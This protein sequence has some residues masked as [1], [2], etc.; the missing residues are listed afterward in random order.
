MLKSAIDLL[1][2]PKSG[3]PLTLTHAVERNGEVAEGTLKG[4]GRTYAITNGIARLADVG[5]AGQRQTQESFGFKW[6]QQN[7][8]TSKPVTAAFEEWEVK[9]YGFASAAAMRDYF[10]SRQRILDAGCG[11]GLSTGVWMK[12]GWQRRPDAQYF[13]VDISAAIDVVKSRLGH[14]SGTQFIQADLMELPFAPGTFDT[15]FSEGVLHHTPS[16]RA[17]LAS[18]VK[19]LSAGGE[20]LFYVYV[21]KAPIR[22]FADDWVREQIASLPPEQAWEAMKPLTALGQALAALK[23]TV[24][25]PQDIPYLGV[26][27]GEYDVQRFLYWH[28]LKLFW[29]D[30]FSF[31]ENNHINFDWYHP[32]YAHRQTEEEVRTWCDELGLDIHHFD[33]QESGMTVRAIKRA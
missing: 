22:E 29:N 14:I 21:K 15:V 26:K 23:T 27:A 3:T 16:T 20:I 30:D 31:D 2:D 11:G 17:A 4:D 33:K 10:G 12:E 1:V 8:Y 7:T 25:V 28:V 19:A 5:D 18:V 32:R 13:G 6:Q 24:A 9:R